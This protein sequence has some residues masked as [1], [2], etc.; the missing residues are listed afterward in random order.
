MRIGGRGVVKMLVWPRC[1][2]RARRPERRRAEMARRARRLYSQY[3]K[4]A[5]HHARTDMGDAFSVGFS[6]TTSFQGDSRETWAASADLHGRRR[7][8]AIS[9]DA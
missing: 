3:E 1:S 4:G 2:W 9:S 6:S 8:P 5:W 7:Y